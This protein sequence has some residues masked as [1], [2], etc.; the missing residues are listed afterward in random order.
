M[1]NTDRNTI[2]PASARPRR[3]LEHGPK[4]QHLA[5]DKESVPRSNVVSLPKVT[6]GRRA[7]QDPSTA[8]NPLQQLRKVGSRE[9]RSRVPRPRT[10]M[11]PGRNAPRRDVRSGNADCR[12]SSGLR[13]AAAR[14]TRP[15]KPKIRTAFSSRRP[16]A[17][18]VQLH[19]NIAR[20]HLADR[21]IVNSM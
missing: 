5:A 3:L 14:R 9:K 6:T 16:M 4:V 13:D 20:A 10:A 1:Y 19:E 7:L 8:T 15:R 18:P 17:R 21:C 2:K 12:T 11:L